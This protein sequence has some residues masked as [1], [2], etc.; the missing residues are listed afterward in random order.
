MK[1]LDIM[2]PSWQCGGGF[3]KNCNGEMY[4]YHTH[5]KANSYGKVR[6]Y[7]NGKAI[8]WWKFIPP[9]A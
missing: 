3:D 5:S 2:N 4:C 6:S 8:G 1:R 7:K 9:I